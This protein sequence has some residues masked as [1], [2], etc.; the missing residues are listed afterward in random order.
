MNYI[1][2]IKRPTKEEQKVAMES[3]TALSA[4][5]EQLKTNNPEIEIEETKEKVVIPLSALKLLAHILKVT[6]QGNPVS[7]IP[8][9][10]EMTTQA[11]AEFLGCSRPHLVKLL[12]EGAIPFTKVGKHR[13]VRFEDLAEYKMRQREQRELLLIHSD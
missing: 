1:E 12:E 2:N 5:I 11:A 9:A 8:V 3:Y 4:M 10:T 6:G 13:R 7:I